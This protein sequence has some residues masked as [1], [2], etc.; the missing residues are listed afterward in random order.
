VSSSDKSRESRFAT[1]SSTFDAEFDALKLA[2]E[3][4]GEKDDPEAE[5]P[6]AARLTVRRKRLTRRQAILR[7]VTNFL[8]S[9]ALAGLVV[10]ALLGFDGDEE[11]AGLYASFVLVVFVAAL[12][13]RQRYWEIGE[14][15]LPVNNEFD[16][17]KL[18]LQPPERQALKLLQ[19][20]SL[21]LRR[22][23]GQALRHASFIFWVGV[24]CLLMGFGVVVA[25]LLLLERGTLDTTQEQFIVGGLAAVSSL[26]AN[27]IGAI[28]LRMYAQ[29]VSSLGSFH[30][31]L[32][33]T[34]H[35][36]FANFLAANVK[37]DPERSRTLADMAIALASGTPGTA[38]DQ[39]PGS[40]VPLALAAPGVAPPARARQSNGAATP[41]LSAD[42]AQPAKRSRRRRSK[43]GTP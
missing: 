21:E 13:C 35:L 14:E 31:R 41:G 30:Q 10:V 17:L 38:Q 23:Y 5:I 16:R 43:V 25:V 28:Y 2:I 18:S 27:F 4:R 34:H 7:M 29:T 11:K 32:V 3:G 39:L 1:L 22:Y 24:M 26:M 37:D 6:R 20:H 36:H 12:L 42:G 15:L 19:N 9:A 40:M 8:F 33:G